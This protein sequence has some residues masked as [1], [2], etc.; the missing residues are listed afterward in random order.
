MNSYNDSTYKDEID[1]D[2]KYKDELV[3]NS[4]YKDQIDSI[5]MKRIEKVLL[6]LKSLKI[7]Y[8]IWFHPPLPTI[9]VAMNYWKDLPGTHCKNLFFRN[10]KGNRHYLVILECNSVMNIHSLEQNLKQGKLSFAS[11]ERMK[12][13]LG[14][15]PGS[16]TPFGLINDTDKHVTLFI[17]KSLKNSE[18][19]SFHPNDNRASVVISASDFFR[20]LDTMGNKYFIM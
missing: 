19:L 4:I 11:E 18:Y 6:S 14:V 9:E 17:D 15:N 20:F 3:N 5:S 1:H 7:D 12:R 2:S 16:V 13:F 8:K 10:H